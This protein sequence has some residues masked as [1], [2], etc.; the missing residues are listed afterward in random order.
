MIKKEN[1]YDSYAYRISDV[2]ASAGLVTA[3]WEE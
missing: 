3:G 2:P 1:R